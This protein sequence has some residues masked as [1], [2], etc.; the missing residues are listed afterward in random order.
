MLPLRRS[1]AAAA[2]AALLAAASA[3]GAQTTVAGTVVDS[4]RAAA[5]LAG[6]T[7]QL[8]SRS[9]ADV[10]RTAT[11]DSLGGWSIDAV[12]PGEWLVGFLHP[13]LDELALQPPLRLLRTA[14][15]VPVA[16]VDLA[17]PGGRTV[18][19]AICGAAPDST[20]LLM[21]R[22][23]DAAS[24]GVPT[25]APTVT[26]S[27]PEIVFA[28]GGLR[29]ERRTR[30]APVTGDGRYVACGLPTDVAVVVRATAGVAASGDVELQ[31]RAD[32]VA[33]RDLLVAPIVTVV[34]TTLPPGVEPARRGAARLA[35][36]VRRE[37]GA[38]MQR[39]VVLVH[40]SGASDTTDADGAFALD[41]LP[42]GTFT[43][44][45]R[46]IGYQPGR[47]VVDLRDGAR[48]TAEVTLGERV[49]TLDAVT[50]Y[51]NAPQRG[52][53][54][55]FMHRAQ[56][57]SGYFVT[58]ADIER[59]RP[60]AATDLLRRVPGVRLTPTGGTGVAIS[61]RGPAAGIG[62]CLPAVF[63]DG[64]QMFDGAL[65]LDRIVS[66]QE[67]AAIEVYPGLFVPAQ[68]QRSS[69]GAVVVWTK[70]RWR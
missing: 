52:L 46:A 34:D 50:V 66:S 35:G 43:L 40:G 44:E 1:P 18:A 49:P 62:G 57:G 51:G 9:A 12:A 63:V 5:P 38:P 26:V 27:W 37:N 15:S 31:V 33:Q 42:A 36:R 56:A 7:V 54:T 13:R 41:S 65:A 14:D 25:A 32:D 23:R 64:M 68:F 48:A 55:E 39:S 28:D 61:I 30:V 47:V 59:V 19:A 53:I 20:G 69:C 17:V 10:V 4:T 21:G 6:A 67:V 8:V 60:F 29:R 58:P 24:G 22:V 3:A 16:R 45:A 2:V 11:T 70:M